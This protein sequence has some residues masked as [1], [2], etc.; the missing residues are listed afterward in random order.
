[1]HNKDVRK[2]GRKLALYGGVR[3]RKK[4]M[5]S[6]L[7]FG[8]A[9]L[10]AVG[11]LFDYYASKKADF[12]YQG[13]YEWLY[14]QA[15]V[16]YMGVKGF[17]DAV[18]SGTSALYVAIAALNL[19]PQSHVM[20]SPV[21]D[22][23]TLSAIILNRLIPVIT[24]SSPQCYNIGVEEFKARI[25]K[26]I[27]AAVIVHIGGKVA[28]V[29]IICKIARKNEIRIIEDCSQSHGA[30]LNGRK[31]GTFG[32][33]AA[34]STMYRKA[35]ATGGCGG[36]IFTR[37]KKYYRLIRAYADRG[38]PFFK[39]GFDE[40]DPGSF[41]FPALNLNIDEISCAIGIESLKKLDAMIEKRIEFL[42][43]LGRRISGASK[44]CRL[45][46]VLAGDSPFF[47]PVLIDTAK[48][49]CS[50]EEF[51]RAVM[52]EGIDINPDYKYVVSEWRWARPYLADGYP[53]K[54]AVNFRKGSFNLLFNE[55]YGE[56]EIKDILAAL[57]QV[58]EV[59]AS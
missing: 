42:I 57:L 34:F 58:E 9:E 24:D 37:S 6:R 18:N 47:Q 30:K 31:V 10:D 36:V 14:N 59:Y 4:P 49:S 16:R 35:H 53:A 2:Q 51:A 56:Q 3:V 43:A 11:R 39:A 25:S 55:N 41:M 54:N 1:M 19:K 52:A 27:K 8:P 7:A 23:G 38:K 5:P 13:K 33:I 45:A 17:S 32:D 22:P 29:D 20:V 48:I 50:K 46:G 15:F 28:P 12:G 40:K 26:K 21:T 44:V